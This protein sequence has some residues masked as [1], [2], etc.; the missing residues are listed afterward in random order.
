MVRINGDLAG[1]PRFTPFDTGVAGPSL[2]VL[3]DVGTLWF[4][5]GSGSPMVVRIS[6]NL[7]GTPTI[8]HVNTSVP[9]AGFTIVDHLGNV[10]FGNTDSGGSTN[11][12]RVP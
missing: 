2:P 7:R 8:S 5:N 9:S 6:G 3:D 1:Q 10:W 4:G 11:L 12:V